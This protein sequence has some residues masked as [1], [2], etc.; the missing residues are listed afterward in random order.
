[1]GPLEGC[2]GCKSETC[3][4]EHREELVKLAGTG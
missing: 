3:R 1:M 2:E 4:A